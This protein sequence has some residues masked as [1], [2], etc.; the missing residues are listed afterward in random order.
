MKKMICLSIAAMVIAAC[1]FRGFKPAPDASAGWLLHKWANPYDTMTDEGF[2]NYVVKQHNDFWACGIDPIGGNFDSS[3]QEANLNPT[4]SEAGGYLC[5]ESKGWYNTKGP[6]C[7]VEWLYFKK[8]E[9]VAWR[10]A[11]GLSNA[12]KPPKPSGST[13]Y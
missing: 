13:N 3:R 5:L 7:L 2:Y 6:T 10:Q 4:N 8:P 12:P 1:S 11:R 9:C